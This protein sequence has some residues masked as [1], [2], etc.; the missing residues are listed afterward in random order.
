MFPDLKYLNFGKAECGCNTDAS[1]GEAHCTM[2]VS[3]QS[4]EPKHGDM[5][6]GGFIQ[7]FRNK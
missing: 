5:I 3:E 6:V 2:R 7:F 4:Q 1:P